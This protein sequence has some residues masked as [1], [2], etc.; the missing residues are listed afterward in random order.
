MRKHL[1]IGKASEGLGAKAIALGDAARDTKDWA[2]AAEHYAKALEVFPDNVGIWVQLGNMRKEAEDFAASEAAYQ[3]ALELRPED[4]DIHLQMGHLYKRMDE[5]GLAGESYRLALVR[6]PAN[7]DAF[8]ELDMLGLRRIADRILR[9]VASESDSQTLVFDVSDLVFYIGH[10][11]H[12]TGIQ[13]VQCS[14]I[15]AIVRNRLYDPKSIQFISYDRVDHR[16]QLINRAKFI[17]LLEDLSLPEGSRIVTFNQQHARHGRLFP[18][19][20]ITSV[21]AKQKCTLVLL[22]AAWVIPDY[23][24]LIVSLK[25]NFDARFVMVFHDLIP[26]FARETCDQGTANSFKVYIDQIIDHVDLA[27]CVSENTARDLQRYCASTE[28][29]PPPT[30]V[31]KLGS[32]FTEF[33]MEVNDEDTSEFVVLPDEPF[34]LFVSTVEGRKNHD[35]ILQI[36][37]ALQ[38]QGVE[39]PRLLCV[40]RLGWRSENFL[41]TLLATD[42][43]SGKVEIVETISDAQLQE[44]YDDCMFTLFPS[45]YEGWGLPVG[46]SLAHGKI[47][48]VS[49]RASLPE[50][51]GDLGV[52]IPLDDVQAATAIVRDL[53]VDPER[54]ARLEQEIRSSFAPILW[55]D[56]AERVVSGC[57]AARSG[58][59]RTPYPMVEPGREYPVRSML[60]KDEG[61]MGRDLVESVMAAHSHVIVEGIA[62]PR[63]I[64]HGL[65]A[66]DDNW[67]E[68]QPGLC[69]AKEREAGLEFAIR[70]KDLEGVDSLIFYFAFDSGDEP[71]P[72]RLDIA[73]GQGRDVAKACRIDSKE[74]IITWKVPTGKIRSGRIVEDD[75]VLVNITFESE[76]R[77]IR[78]RKANPA[79]FGLRS[80]LVLRGDDLMG[81][82][83][84]I[85]NQSFN[86]IERGDSTEVNALKKQV[87]KR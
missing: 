41:K 42:Y 33:V 39:V 75:L 8:R 4:A 24:K 69:R 70:R 15:L 49:D 54:R 87:R 59:V 58:A 72:F 18:A 30:Q 28:I 9:R 45:L 65:A 17:E 27:L 38:R 19:G 64:A 23:P 29:T 61:L 12:L 73:L 74:Q 16:F 14:I 11:P 20:S 34:V 56:V 53:I 25:R 2:A 40:G 52:Y 26:I 51:A 47:C 37:Q 79:R 48:V 86:G 80:F 62:S 32:G 78:M 35:Y 7:E 76:A 60:S 22:G 85:E 36:W 46:E 21:M 71:L 66:R 31:T 6:D 44:L 43:L 50:V 1:N 81:R 84:V 5:I 3:Q 83:A 77:A 57:A 55:K 82:M 68:A 63:T 67:L 13:R 10:H